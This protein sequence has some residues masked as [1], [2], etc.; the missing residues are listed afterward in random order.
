MP[1]THVKNLTFTMSDNIEWDQRTDDRPRFYFEDLKKILALEGGQSET[2]SFLLFNVVYD[3]DRGDENEPDHEIRCLGLIGDDP[4][5]SILNKTVE[6][7]KGMKHKYAA[8]GCPPWEVPG[9]DVPPA[10]GGIPSLFAQ[11][12]DLEDQTKEENE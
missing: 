8:L 12:D 3:P 10:I 6:E 7:I 11:S 9:V 4:N 1:Y 2:F 5:D